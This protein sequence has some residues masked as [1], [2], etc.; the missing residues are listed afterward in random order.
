METF[1]G[2]V[3]LG[4]KYFR[5]TNFAW[6]E[7]FKVEV[8]FL[9]GYFFICH[10]AQ[11]EQTGDMEDRERLSFTNHI[12]CAS[13]K[14]NSV[15]TCRQRTYSLMESHFVF[16]SSFYSRHHSLE[17]EINVAFIQWLKKIYKKKICTS[18]K[19][20]SHDYNFNLKT[21]NLWDFEKLKIFE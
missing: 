14:L 6:Q 5:W 12:A 21:E 15:L 11:D 10:M 16:C 19:G 1:L 18:V 8:C 7:S 17:T 3:F 4:S 9:S 2:A 20:K 13:S